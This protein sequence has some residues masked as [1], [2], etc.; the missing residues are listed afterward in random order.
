MTRSLGSG[1]GRLTAHS[2]QV[3]STVNG[4]AAPAVPLGGVGPVAGVG[5][6]SVMGLGVGSVTSVVGLGVGL[7]TS[8]EVGSVMG[9]GVGSAEDEGGGSISETVSMPP[10]NKG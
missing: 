2:V 4:G 1:S 8:V 10:S 7:V 5:V 9:L 3:G 6:G